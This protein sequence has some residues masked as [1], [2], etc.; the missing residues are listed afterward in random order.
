GLLFWHKC[1]DRLIIEGG[2]NDWIPVEGS[3]FAGNV[4]QYGIGASYAVYK[5]CKCRISP[6]VEFVGWSVL[7]GKDTDFTLGQVTVETQGINGPGTA[8]GAV[9]AVGTFG[10]SARTT[11]VNVKGGVRFDFGNHW[12]IYAGYGHALTGEKWYRD[13]ARLEVRWAF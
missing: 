4:I 9:G 12:S 2:I 10:Q 6:V 11:I 3:D 8:L 5:T 13:L 1:N 7:G